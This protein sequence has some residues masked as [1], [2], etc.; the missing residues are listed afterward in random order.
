MAIKPRIKAIYRSMVKAH[1]DAVP[2]RMEVRRSAHTPQVCGDL[3]SLF[4]LAGCFARISRVEVPT[5]YS[6]HNPGRQNPNLRTVY[7]LWQPCPASVATQAV[8]ERYGYHPQ[9][10]PQYDGTW[11][12]HYPNRGMHLRRELYRVELQTLYFDI[13]KEEPTP[14]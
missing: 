7:F 8:L 13:V 10:K 1:L 14:M 12:R 6:G 5:Q 9:V 11:W 2:E 4:W 3:I